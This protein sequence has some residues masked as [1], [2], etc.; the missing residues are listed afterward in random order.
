[1]NFGYYYLL[2]TFVFDEQGNFEVFRPELGSNPVTVKLYLSLDKLM[3]IHWHQISQWITDD[4]DWLTLRVSHLLFEWR[5]L[6]LSAPYTNPNLIPFSHWINCRFKF[7]LIPKRLLK[8][9]IET[10]Y[11]RWGELVKQQII[12]VQSAFH[13]SK[14]LCLVSPS[15]QDS[16]EFFLQV[17]FYL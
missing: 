1:M 17:L 2:N 9:R 7:S 12:G 11:L 4:F 10:S 3:Q 6:H 13:S 8:F 16:P 15:P 5:R 14:V